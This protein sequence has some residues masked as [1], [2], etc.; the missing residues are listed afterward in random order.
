M[1]E[2]G[3]EIQK[4]WTWSKTTHFVS[5]FC[6]AGVVQ[7]FSE[8]Q[9]GMVQDGLKYFNIVTGKWFAHCS[10]DP[11]SPVIAMKSVLKALSLAES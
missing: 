2:I 11:L 6:E 1:E 5:V 8:A 10:L 3:G 9:A 7:Q 4:L